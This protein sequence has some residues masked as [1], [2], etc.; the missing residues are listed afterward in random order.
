MYLFYSAGLLP[1]AWREELRELAAKVSLA[2][3]ANTTP[4]VQGLIVTV[5][6]RGH[7]PNNCKGAVCRI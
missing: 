5:R 2:S 6:N 4:E 1:E 3:K 7:R